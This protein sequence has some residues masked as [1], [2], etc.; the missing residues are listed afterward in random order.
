MHSLPLRVCDIVPSSYEFPDEE[1][2]QQPSRSC[3]GDAARHDRDTLKLGPAE[4]KA[5][6]AGVTETAN[7]LPRRGRFTY[8]EQHAL[9]GI[10]TQRLGTL[11]TWLRAAI[12]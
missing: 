9:A 12:A 1:A 6:D 10:K 7:M 4:L 5:A 8:L 11:I 2:Y 3:G